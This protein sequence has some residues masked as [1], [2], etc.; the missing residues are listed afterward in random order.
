MASTDLPS[1]AE[2]AALTATMRDAG[3]LDSG[4]VSDVTVIS[5]RPMLVSR[6]IRL[7]LTYDGAAPDAPKTLIL[8]TPLPAFAKTLWQGGRHEVTFYRELARVMPPRLVP[9]GFGGAW[10]EGAMTWHLLLE[11][12]TDTH[13]MATQW[14][15]PP[16]VPDAE[17][18]VRAL[19]RLHAAWWDDPRLGVS[20]GSFA[21]PEQTAANVSEFAGHYARFADQLGDRLSAERRAIY[22]RFLAATPQLLE[23]YHSRRNLSI[24]HGD[25]HVWNFLVPKAAGSDDV[26]VFDFDH[27]RINVPAQDLAYMI[28]LHLFPER[29]S[30]VERPLLDCYHETLVAHGVTGYD[31][32]A[33][34]RD[35]RYAVLWHI[36]KPVWQW[37][38][39]IPP[40]IWWAHL[41]R[42]FRAI[43]DLGCRDLL[44]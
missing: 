1:A 41:E 32:A 31:R 21:T 22:E 25:A 14:P 43:D 30:V 35:Y 38:I 37:A 39:E 26:R 18:I 6:I 33:L 13:R 9:G 12:L 42:I 28:A 5:D 29:R 34:D 27:W 11:D 3:V 24:A 16:T 15:L 7:G 44:D 23:R 4:T 8:K 2:P 19:A 10:D 40:L 36:T 17:R 20:V